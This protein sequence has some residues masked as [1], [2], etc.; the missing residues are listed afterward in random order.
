MRPNVSNTARSA[1]LLFTLGAVWLCLSGQLQWWVGDRAEVGAGAGAQ[2]ARTM[3]VILGGGVTAV[4][5]VPQHTLL[6]VQRAYS[7]YETLQERAVFV[8]LSGES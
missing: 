2:E 5:G 1:M 4:G 7:L 8:T 3:V 6:R